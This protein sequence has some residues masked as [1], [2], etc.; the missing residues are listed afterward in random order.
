[1]KTPFHRP[2]IAAVVAALC[3]APAAFAKKPKDDE[4]NS[5]PP[6][7][8]GGSGK[9]Q[10]Q[11]K[12]GEQR[13]AVPGGVMPQGPG[14]TAPQGRGGSVSRG[15]GGSGSQGPGRPGIPGLR[16]VVPPPFPPP[17]P[18]HYQRSYRRSS[19]SVEDSTVVSVQRSL[20]QRGYYS[21]SIDG[22]AGSGTRA[23]IRGFREDNGMAPVSVIDSALLRAL[24]L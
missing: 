11:G 5:G 14:G 19:S 3:I 9:H 15:P 10:K 2:I 22:D 13:A 6:G 12:S 17:P 21:G 7:A 24:G 8:P 1:M 23:A 4:Q 20:K 16:I 18:P